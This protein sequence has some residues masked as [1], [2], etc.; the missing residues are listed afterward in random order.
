MHLAVFFKR[1]HV[2]FIDPASVMQQSANECALAVIN[3]STGEKPQQFVAFI[4]TEVI[5]HALAF[6]HHWNGCLA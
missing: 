3:A 1:G 2:I 4:A 5:L 6:V